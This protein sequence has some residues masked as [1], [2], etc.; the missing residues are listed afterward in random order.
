MT[1]FVFFCGKTPA[2]DRM[3]LIYLKSKD[4]SNAKIIY[5]SCQIFMTNVTF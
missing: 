3:Q 2:A 4:F 1:S 5:E